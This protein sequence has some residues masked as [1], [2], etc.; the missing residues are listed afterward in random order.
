MKERKKKSTQIRSSRSID[1]SSKDANA[2]VVSDPQL[3]KVREQELAPAQAKK[4]HQTPR[5][6]VEKSPDKNLANS[7]KHS[8]NLME[9]SNLSSL[10]SPAQEESTE[11][12]KLV[13]HYDAIIEGMKKSHETELELLR[14]K[15]TGL[16]KNLDEKQQETLDILT[17][18]S[19]LVKIHAEEKTIE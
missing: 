3:S 8:S 6:S 9:G 18:F 16:S 17:R 7:D 15:I 11:L 13:V 2:S 4:G 14:H 19:P 12:T 10:H 1:T 5:Q